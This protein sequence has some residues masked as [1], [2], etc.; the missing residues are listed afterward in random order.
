M[1]SRLTARTIALLVGA[2]LLLGLI[3]FALHQWSNART[4]AAKA[5]LGAAQG[6]AATESGKDA[7]NTVATAGERE[8]AIQDTTETNDADIRAAKGADAAVD[9]AARDAGR[10]A[11]CLRPG[12]RDSRECIELLGHVAK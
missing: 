11:L 12:Y 2:A 10:R 5:R 1:L 7:V 8:R 9:P 3:A 6:K 4:S